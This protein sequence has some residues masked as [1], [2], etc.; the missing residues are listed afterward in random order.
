MTPSV[1]VETLSVICSVLGAVPSLVGLRG[2]STAV[3]VSVASVRRPA[4]AGLGLGSKIFVSVRFDPVLALEALELAVGTSRGRV[5]AGVVLS[6][7]PV[8]VDTGL[9]LTFSPAPAHP[10][11]VGTVALADGA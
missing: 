7:R 2:G 9:S 11:V 4:T 6:R 8:R 1:R 3:S 10:H 5:D